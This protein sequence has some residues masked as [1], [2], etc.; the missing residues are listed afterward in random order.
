MSVVISL[1]RVMADIV[2]GGIGCWLV[3]YSVLE[4]L[5][6]GECFG[7]LARL[8]RVNASLVTCGA[9]PSDLVEIV[10]WSDKLRNFVLFKCLYVNSN[11]VYKLPIKKSFQSG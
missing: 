1:E 10:N 9:A 6:N 5:L 8:S 11:G 7:Y 3:V 2:G 4:T